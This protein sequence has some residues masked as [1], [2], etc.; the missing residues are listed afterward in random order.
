MSLDSY[1]RVRSAVARWL[2]TPDLDAAIPDFITLAEAQLNRLIDDDVNLSVKA[3]WV[4]SGP[5]RAVPD[6]FNGLVSLSGSGGVVRYKPPV[7]L[8]DLEAFAGTPQ[9]Y[10][11]AAGKVGVWPQPDGPVV[12]TARYRVRLD[13]LNLGPNW[14]IEAHPDVYVFGALI[15]AAGYV[16]GEGRLP[17]WQARFQAAVDQ[18]NERARRASVGGGPLQVKPAAGV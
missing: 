18:I 5:E 6:D 4:F 15:E 1:S 11:V 10:T 17:V 2:D 14:L 8:F 16:V 9:F 3:D 12:L 13:A 7:E